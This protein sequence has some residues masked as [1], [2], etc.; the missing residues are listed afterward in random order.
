MQ[1]SIFILISLDNLQCIAL[2]SE[3]HMFGFNLLNI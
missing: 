2:N 3:K 1:T